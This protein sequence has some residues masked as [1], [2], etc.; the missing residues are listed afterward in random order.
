MIS[1]IVT[2]FEKDRIYLPV[3][4]NSVKKQSITHEVIVVDGSKNP[5]PKWI[6]NHKL[7]QDVKYIHTPSNQP[8]AINIGVRHAIHDWII[9][10]DSDDV[11]IPE[12]LQ[13]LIDDDFDVIFGN[14]TFDGDN[15]V[16]P[17]AKGGLSK[18]LLISTNPLF[19][20]S[21]FKKNAWQKIGGLDESVL[22]QDY[23]MWCNMYKAGC[24]FKYVDKLIFKHNIR[25]GS[26]TYKL[27]NRDEELRKEATSC[28]R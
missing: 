9:V 21:L 8:T 12:S 10:L 24:K 7:L 3:A 1:I 2:C 4:L 26:L 13:T 16:Q 22:Y 19:N 18:E 11:L 17:Q 6:A 15:I 14:I 28:L 5:M 27:Q 20:T 23:W 25:P